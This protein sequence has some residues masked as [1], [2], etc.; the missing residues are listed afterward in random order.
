[1]KQPFQL[2]D[3]HIPLPTG[4]GLGIEVDEEYLQANLYDG[5][6]DLPRLF[7]ADGSVADW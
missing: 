7:H 6:W 3:G 5:S 1:L 2:V 4:P